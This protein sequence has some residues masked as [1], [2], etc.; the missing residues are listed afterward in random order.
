MPESTLSNIFRGLAFKCQLIFS[1]A[2]G[3]VLFVCLTYL[4]HNSVLKEN[5]TQILNLP[6]KIYLMQLCLS[7]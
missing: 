4:F 3:A 5:K 1:H 2:S 7:I 6:V